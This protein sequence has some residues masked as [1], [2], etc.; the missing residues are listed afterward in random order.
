MDRQITLV[1]VGES[2][3]ADEARGLLNGARLPF[4]EVDI[5]HNGAAAYL[6]RD[7][8]PGASLPLLVVDGSPIS[9]L[10]E[11]RRFAE[12]FSVGK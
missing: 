1:I 3:I 7:F 5:R 11:I 8:G 9:G 10:E 12:N 4:D 2:K 6:A